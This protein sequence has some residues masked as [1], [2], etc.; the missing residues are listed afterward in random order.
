MSRSLAGVA[1]IYMMLGV[2]AG[3]SAVASVGDVATVRCVVGP[4]ALRSPAVT[5]FIVRVVR[6]RHAWPLESR[7]QGWRQF[8]FV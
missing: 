6:M 2:V 5:R 4:C 8:G 7:A 3:A 1:L